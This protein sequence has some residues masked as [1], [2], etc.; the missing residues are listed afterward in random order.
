MTGEQQPDRRLTVAIGL[1][2]TAP[3]TALVVG[4]DRDDVSRAALG[5]AA[6]LAARLAARLASEAP[7]LDVSGLDAG[8]SLC[9][10][11]PLTDDRELADRLRAQGVA[12]EALSYYQQLPDPERGLVLDINATG[13]REL[14]RVLAAIADRGTVAG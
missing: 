7:G 11:A 9:V 2:R 4:F 5:V 3:E 8:L 1:P 12:C 13:E 6:D 14:D 10:R